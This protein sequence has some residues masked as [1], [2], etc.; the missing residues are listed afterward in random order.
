MGFLDSL[1][2]N[3]QFPIIFIGS[4]ITQRYFSDAPTWDSLLQNLWDEIITEK[5]YF[6]RFKELSNEYKE[7]NFKIYTI[8]ADELEELFDIQFFNEKI[9]VDSLTPRIAH[10]K[11]ISPFKTRIANIF[12]SL[13]IRGDKKEELKAFKSMLVKSRLIVTTNYD[14][15]IENQLNKSIK[16]RVGNAGLFEPS[17]DLNE[18]YKI[19]GSVKQPNSIMITSNDYENMKRTSAIVNAKILTYLTESPIL[20]IGYS[21]TD[22]NIQS[23]LKDLADNMPFSIEEASKRIGVIQYVPGNISVNEVMCDTD[24]GV[25]YTQLSTDNYIKIYNLISK[26]DQGIS[27][28]II[29]KFQHAFKTIIDT[30]GQKGELNEVLTSFVDLENLPKELESKNLVVALGDKRYL[31]KYPDYVDYVK[32]YFEESNAMPPEIA[33][34]FIVN[35]SPQSTLPI[36]RYLKER[37]GIKEVEKE[38]I[39]KRLE[40]FGSLSSLQEK[41]D[42]PR[43]AERQFKNYNLKS[44][45]EIFKLEDN[46]KATSK[47]AYFIKHIPDIDVEPL[48]KYILANEKDGFIKETNTRKLF[49]AYSLANEKVFEKIK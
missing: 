42:I 39:N 41:I 47:L 19:H 36:S 23:L 21:L 14:E 17:G 37:M 3:N 48:I 32:S 2:K 40:K 26:I 13:E 1:E 44:P 38:K 43:A 30:K 20:F 45:V 28:L 11:K 15:F 35:T 16:V 27:P 25:H 9:K 10:E 33:I 29:S 7:D 18:L 6:A 31:Y 34:K 4:G 12:S 5:S 22:K 46:I 8:I 24:Y 49:M